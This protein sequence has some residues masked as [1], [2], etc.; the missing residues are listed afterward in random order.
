MRAFAQREAQREDAVGAG[1][2][3]S[4]DAGDGP[5]TADA[6]AP[7]IQ[8][9][10]APQNVLAAAPALTPLEAALFERVNADR[11]ALGLRPLGLDTELIHA[12]RQRAAAQASRP[13]LSHDDQSGQPA[14][15]DLLA[16]AGL[17]YRIAGE[18][19]VRL[20]GTDAGVAG[21]AEEALMN[22][23]GHR[24]NILR[25]EFDRLAIGQDI[26]DTGRS[27][28]AQLFRASA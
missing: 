21:R 11:A 3:I 25:P 23:P 14:L 6:I 9:A 27:T 24:T 16:A 15:A 12:S 17:R 7:D 5:A 2:P 4:S 13:N 26:D 1:A 22:S 20:P 28:F 10:R 19:L 8:D 18:T